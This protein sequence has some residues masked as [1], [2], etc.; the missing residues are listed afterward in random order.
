MN[1]R[2]SWSYAIQW[3]LWAVAMGAVMGW[4]AR[5]RD[6]VPSPGSVGRMAHPKSTLIVGVVGTVFFV[7]LAVLSAVFPGKTGTLAVSAAFLGFAALNALMLLE[8][9]NAR[10]ELLPDGMRFGGLFR[11]GGTLRW[12]ELRRVSYSESMKWFV[13]ELGDKRLVRISVMVTGRRSTRPRARCSSAPRQ[14]TRRAS[15]AE[16]G[17]CVKEHATAAWSARSIQRP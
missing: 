5:S 17:R 11:R 7:L 16:R 1:T 4:M 6:A 10:H 13:L 12:A 3:G 9:R 15:G 8:Y 2:P 14:A